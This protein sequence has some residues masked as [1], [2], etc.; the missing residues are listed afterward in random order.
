MADIREDDAVRRDAEIHRLKELLPRHY[1]NVKAAAHMHIEL[2][3]TKPPYW[4]NRDFHFLDYIALHSK[5]LPEIAAGIDEDIRRYW[6][7]IL[8]KLLSEHDELLIHYKRILVGKSPTGSFSPLN[9]VKLA[10]IREDLDHTQRSLPT[11]IFLS[12]ADVER[13][14]AMTERCKSPVE[15]AHA[16]HQE[17]ISGIAAHAQ[18]KAEEIR[19]T[20]LFL[21]KVAPRA[22]RALAGLDL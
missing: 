16:Y 14:T 2:A 9:D 7:N 17:I 6:S 22:L 18:A 4:Y 21:A 11:Y 19:K 12:A 15:E 5:E 8:R 13:W 10:A 20:G 1:W 3:I